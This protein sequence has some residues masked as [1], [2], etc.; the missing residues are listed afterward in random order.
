MGI[1]IF[2]NSNNMHIPFGEWLDPIKDELFLI[3]D[4]TYNV[5][6]TKYKAI[7]KFS[8]YDNNDQV[9]EYAK[10]IIKEYGVRFI[11][12]KSECDILR[13]AKLR[14]EFNIDGQTYKQS[15]PYRNKIVMKNY[16]KS[17]NILI[18]NFCQPKNLN[19]AITF[20]ENNQFPL[21][22]KPIDGS[23]SFNTIK[24]NCMNDM[25]NVN[26]FKNTMLEEFI[27]GKMYHV[28]GLYLNDNIVF[29][30]PSVYESG[31]LEFQ[32]KKSLKSYTL[33]KIIH[34]LIGLKN[35]PVKL[36]MLYQHIKI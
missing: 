8:K 10:S 15:L 1:L 30:S 33:A 36:L 3:C 9:L 32:S 22:L 31:C 18:A 5:T 34:F 25:Y 7:K 20:A 4:N 13:C 14:D 29:S 2:S 26:S 27:D 21:I 28:D 11:I 6:H 19:E 23:G 16:L 35:L 12:G 24:I 17:H